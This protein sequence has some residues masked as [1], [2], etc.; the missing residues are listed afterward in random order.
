MHSTHFNNLQTL[1]KLKRPKQQFPVPCDDP[2][3]THRP[4]P[5][6][7]KHIKNSKELATFSQNEIHFV[8][9]FR[10]SQTNFVV[11]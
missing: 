1:S 11:R 5:K 6:K 8:F 4:W 2:K 3:A 7:T 10:C 9:Q